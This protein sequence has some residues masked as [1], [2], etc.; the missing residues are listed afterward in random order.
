MKGDGDTRQEMPGRWRRAITGLVVSAVLVIPCFWQSRIQAGDL[1]SHIY[2]AWLHALISQ[3][4]VKGLR[5]V[6]QSNNVLFD[7]ALDWLLP[8][9]GADAAQRIAVAACVLIFAWGAIAFVWR[10]GGRNGWLIVACVAM[11]SY[12]FV[13]HMGFFNFYV[14]LGIGFW[15]LAIFWRAPWRIRV[16]AAPLL[17][18]AWFAHPLPVAWAVATAAYSAAAQASPPKWRMRL[19]ALALATI[20][21]ARYFLEYRYRCAW[22]AQ[23]AFSM[24]GGGQVLVFDGKY[25]WVFAGLSLVWITLL[26]QLFLR[27]R[28]SLTREISLQLWLLCAAGTLLIPGIIVFPGYGLP[29]SFVTERLSLM[30]G[31]SLC[32]VVA[33]APVKLRENLIMLATAL[34]FFTFIYVDTRKLNQEED[35]IDALVAAVPRDAR[36]IASFPAPHAQVNGMLHMVDRACIGHCFS[37]G[38]YEPSSRQFRIRAQAANGVV[39]DDYADVGATETG[40]YRVQP[41]D[42]P[43]YGVYFCDG[44]G[45]AICSRW[46][47]AGE[48]VGQLANDSGAGQTP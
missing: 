12:G 23:Q 10:V 28:Q 29:F 37:Y 38:N 30:A 27:Q 43:L 7:F 2:N 8:R 31:I 48:V 35:Q 6:R 25:S 24:T 39:F 9:V 45:P 13:Y 34:A 33:G 21:G 41:R 44:H 40:K 18:L 16:L 47:R 11:M 4:S 17:L 1:S 36:V 19:L 15:Y 42:L 14:S 3:G 26:L 22:S 20:A 32:A 5:V 46:L